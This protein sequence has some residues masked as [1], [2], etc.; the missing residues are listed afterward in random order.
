[1]QTVIRIHDIRILFQA[2]KLVGQLAVEEL[3]SAIERARATLVA[4]KGRRQYLQEI[5]PGAAA[6]TV[7]GATETFVVE[8][9][10]ERRFQLQGGTMPLLWQIRELEMRNDTQAIRVIHHSGG[11]QRE[12][13]L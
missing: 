4:A 1:M 3:E 5:L 9:A 7:P 6:C 10:D 2:R 12:Y 13:W 11:E 8:C